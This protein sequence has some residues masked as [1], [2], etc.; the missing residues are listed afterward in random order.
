LYVRKALLALFAA[1]FAPLCLLAHPSLA[2]TAGPWAAAPPVLLYRA[3]PAPMGDN[4]AVSLWLYSD[5]AGGSARV[6]V[7]AT[8]GRAGGPSPVRGAGDD[9]EPLW[10]A[11]ISAPIPLTFSGWK[12]IVLTRDQMTYRPP[13]GTAADATPSLHFA[14]A[15]AVGIDT[16]RRKGTLYMDDIAWVKTDANGAPTGD[17]T[18]VDNFEQGDVAAWTAHGVP[19]AVQAV[20]YGVTTTPAFVKQGRVAMKLDFSQAASLAAAGQH[21]LAAAMAVNHQPY[22]IYVPSSPFQRELPDSTPQ[23]AEIKTSMHVFVCAGQ[24][25]PASFCL[26]SKKPLTDVSVAPKLDLLGVGHKIDRSAIDIRVVKVWEREGTGPLI[27]PDAQG[28]APELLVKDDRQ[29]LTMNGAAPPDVRLTGYPLTDIPAG[30]QKQFWVDIAVP[31]NAPADNYTTELVV[32][33]KEMKP[34]IVSLSVDVLPLHLM[35]PSK[36]YAIGFRGKLGTAPATLPSSDGESLLTDYV[37]KDQFAAQ[38]ADIEDHGFRYATL[39]DT[40]PALWD[41]V[42]AYQQAGLGAPLVYDGLTGQDDIDAI[43]SIEQDRTSRKDPSF[44]YLIPRTTDQAKE[45]ATMK[46]D[47]FQ[48]ASFIPDQTAFDAVKD[49]LDLAIYPADESYAQKLLQTGGHRAFMNRDWWTWPSAQDD[50]QVNRLYTGYLLWRTDLYGAFASDYQTCWGTNPF[51]DSDPGAAAGR[52]MYR[53]AM[54]TYPAANGVIDTIQWEAARE[55]VTDVR[56]LTTFYAAL[57][58]C[59]DN[60]LVPD[61]IKTAQDQVTGFL[62]KSFWEL[63]DSDYQAE[64]QKIAHYAILLRQSV[65]GYYKKQGMPV[66]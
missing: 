13:V 15:D 19:E 53:P 38:L 36:Q 21:R 25:Q 43:K 54:M 51:D 63:S 41:A 1:A 50:P 14:D 49:D 39:T 65:N 64:R 7:M 44:F 12:Q 46:D 28:P 23:I 56:Y 4:T 18:G 20:V 61:L 3:A 57:R 16:D 30:T 17:E 34:I 37:G 59:K 31:E 11:W 5:G 33:A 24:T 27:D 62:D 22:L 8:G 40:G 10:P 60:H 58:E 9:T 45:M 35:N 32:T 29:P 55:G 2:D 6:R 66:Y 26:Y 52:A 47:G 42:D 48:A